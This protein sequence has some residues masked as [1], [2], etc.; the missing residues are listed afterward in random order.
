[1]SH[2][3]STSLPRIVAAAW[4]Q[5]RNTGSKW[6]I[7]AVVA[8]CFATPVGLSIWSLFAEAAL[9]DH[10]RHN[11]RAGFW[12]GL[13]ALLVGGWGMLVNNVLQQNHPT[14]A[15][16]VPGH[17][18]RLRNAL[19]VAWALLV[20]LAAGGPGFV[21]DA[22][23]AWACS[24]A[25]ALAFM[26]AAL[27]WPLLWLAGVAA[28]FAMAWFLGW[29]GHD[30]VAV[31]LR[32]QWQSASW[33][34]MAI[35]ATA[36]GMVLTLM[37]RGG[38]TVHADAYET[39]RRLGR[40]LRTGFD[41]SAPATLPGWWRL[42][43]TNAARPYDRWLRHLLARGDSPLMSRV[44]LGVGPATHW[45]TRLFEAGWF[46]VFCIVL[47]VGF[48]LFL[49]RGTLAF[50]MPFF[51]FSLL[52]ST[53]V[54]ALVALSRLHETRREQALL[55]LLPGVPRGARLSRWLGWQMSLVFVI[56]ALCG[57]ALAWM[58]AAF[59]DGL[60]AGVVESTVGGMVPAL[61]AALLPQVAWQW[62]CVARLRGARGQ[63]ET[64]PSLTPFL[65]GGI[66]MALHL[67]LGVDYMTFGVVATV[68]SLAW[69]A[70]RWHRMGSEPTAFPV[71]RLA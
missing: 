7:V 49:G 3:N 62:R 50:V 40:V 36:G 45:T 27:R 26:A 29:R 11:A 10:L 21:F 53:P 20:L 8:V 64:L 23:L 13:A 47:C 32:A 37:I 48:G 33:L 65:L 2:A 69:C 4:Q 12:G 9:V 51:C 28:P 1:M 66:A 6:G 52:T 18:G 34:V 60:H 25:A 30:A 16:L 71:G 68:A 63:R 70:W 31:E 14:L 24:T 22:P 54:P 15:R 57:M 46:L 44:L 35:V 56:A 59:A 38:G 55:M 17:V 41:G 19:L 58:I 67:K 42:L 5:R 43:G 61:A 39:R